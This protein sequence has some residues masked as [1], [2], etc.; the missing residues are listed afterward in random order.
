MYRNY[1]TFWRNF[2][3]ILILL[4]NLIEVTL[5]ITIHNMKESTV[6]DEH[7]KDDTS[8]TNAREM[9]IKLLNNI[10]G[11]MSRKFSDHFRSIRSTLSGSN[12]SR[13]DSQLLSGRPQLPSINTQ[14]SIGEEPLLNSPD[15]LYWSG[16]NQETT[17]DNFN[18][19]EQYSLIHP[20][21]EEIPPP[22]HVQYIQSLGGAR[23]W[24]WDPD[25]TLSRQEIVTVMDE[26]K[27]IKFTKR[28][29]SMIQTNYPF[30]IPQTEGDVVYEAPFGQP[31]TMPHRQG[32]MLHYFEVTILA[33]PD[34]RNTIIAVGLATKPYPSFRL[35]GWNIHS[36]GFHSNGKKY[37]DSYRGYEY[38]QAWGNAGDTIGCGYNPDVGHVFF[39]KNG[40]FLGNAFMGIR[41]V[42]FPTIGSNGP[43]TIKTNF[44]DGEDEYRFESARGYG[45][46]GPLLMSGEQRHQRHRSESISRNLQTE[47]NCR[48]N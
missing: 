32:Q 26:S 24:E 27:I 41:H 31:E 21:Q 33:N 2:C 19:A 20:P 3:Q 18:A 34:P 38:S 47:D 45:P 42:W 23:A 6:K 11:T 28:L 25:E 30:F 39:T 10:Q 5:G 15:S 16:R 36:V 17:T 44:G 13:S 48:N 22:D 29:D 46:G 14:L 37:N 1:A 12:S 9:M 40:Q 8:S 35:P 4:T 7:T 43:C